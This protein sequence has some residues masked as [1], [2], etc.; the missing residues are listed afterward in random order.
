[1]R[2]IKFRGKREDNGE[3]VYGNLIS[4]SY[5]P[6]NILECF[7]VTCFAGGKELGIIDSFKVIPETV[8]QYIGQNDKNGKEIYERH[9]LRVNDIYDFEVI[10]NEGRFVYTD[11]NDFFRIGSS[12]V[13]IIG[14]TYENPELLKE[15]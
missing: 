7:I 1:M 8:G 11:G 4:S 15:K 6:D 5:L 12:G 13:E 3:W 10:F 14:D 9:I 2:E